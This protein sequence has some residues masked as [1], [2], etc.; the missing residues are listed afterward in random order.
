MSRTRQVK[1]WTTSSMKTRG[2]C[3]NSTSSST[4]MRPVLTKKSL[5]VQSRRSVPA[6][7]P[8]CNL[9]ATSTTE[10]IAVL[11]MKVVF[12]RG[13]ICSSVMRIMRMIFRSM[14][15]VSKSRTTMVFVGSRGT[16]TMLDTRRKT[17]KSTKRHTSR[18][19]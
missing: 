13:H 7:A 12:S 17:L 4:R 16:L 19:T 10:M 14:P 3:I 18:T 2:I 6:K 8:E 15:R 5:S 11:Q 1:W 9:L